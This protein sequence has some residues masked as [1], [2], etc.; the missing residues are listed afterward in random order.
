MRYGA[1]SRPAYRGSPAVLLRCITRL[2][3]SLP[4]IAHIDIALK[5]GKLAD[6]TAPHNCQGPLA[7]KG[8]IR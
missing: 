6:A 3:A 8:A 7:I 4:W 5:T 1:G 2:S